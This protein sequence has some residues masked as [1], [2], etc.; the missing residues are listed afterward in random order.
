MKLVHISDTHLG[1]GGVGPQR[2]V[3]D[4]SRTGILIR[5]QEA[6]IMIGFQQA[7]DRIVENIR[8][9]LVVHSGDLF[10]HSHPTPQS[11][12]FAMR[13][14]RRLSEARIPFV[15]VEGD[16]SSP[17]ILGQGQVLRLLLHLPGVFVVCDAA[18]QIRLPGILIHAIPHR[19]VEERVSESIS[20]D[21][22]SFNILVAHGVADGCPFYNTSRR[23]ASLS[24]SV[25]I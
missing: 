25:F 9:D 11:I 24:G 3:E 20:L 2:H 1:Y 5:Q 4:P 15:I 16:H 8:P 7:I 6:D 10:D 18:A 13:Q 17:R 22:G 23:A 21:E 12:D 14:I 19:A